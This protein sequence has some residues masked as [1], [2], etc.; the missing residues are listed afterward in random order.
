MELIK[1]NFIIIKHS[2]IYFG[3]FPYIILVRNG[4][5]KSN[6]FCVYVNTIIM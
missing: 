5:F 2:K 3:R 1:L 6:N 4:N